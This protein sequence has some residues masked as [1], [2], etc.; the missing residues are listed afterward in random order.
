MALAMLILFL[1]FLLLQRLVRYTGVSEA[2]LFRLWLGLLA[3][4]LARG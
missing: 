1:I 3:V 2:L 4:W